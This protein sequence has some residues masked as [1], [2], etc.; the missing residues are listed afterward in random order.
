MFPSIT[1]DR[2]AANTPG[3]RTLF[4]REDYVEEAWRIVDPVLKA[5]TPIYPYDP[6]PGGR[7]QVNGSMPPRGGWRDPTPSE[8]VT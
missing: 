6:D 7:A 4:A 2:V 1:L 8:P 5:D 3:D